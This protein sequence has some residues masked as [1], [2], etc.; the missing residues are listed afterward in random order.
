MFTGGLALQLLALCY[1]AIDLK[2]YQRWA[3][4]LV[5][6]GVNALAL[7]VLSS[8][9]MKSLV[10]IKAPRLDGTAGDLKTFI[11]ERVFA[12]WLSPINASLAFALGY[13]LLWWLLMLILYRRKI[14]IKL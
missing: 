6:F 1:W 13:V 4:P 3:Q 7:Y 8:L 14:F 11:Y 2:G 10:V 9:M 5:V 12:A